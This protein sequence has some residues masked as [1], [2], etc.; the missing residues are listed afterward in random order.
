VPGFHRRQGELHCDE[1]HVGRIAREAG[2]PVHV[3][4]AALL[5]ERLRMLET[6]FTGSQ[7]RLHYAL[8]ANSTLAIVRLMRELG[9][10]ADA[11]SG[12][13]IEVA[14]RAGFEPREILF[15]GVGKTRA[16]LERAVGLGLAAINVE[17][18]G[19]VDRID[20]LAR[21]RGVR[22]RIAVRVN[23]DI[24][25]GSHPHISTGLGA[26]KFGMAAG[27]AARV[28]RD[29][30]TR[31]SL[32]V[33]GL[34]AHIGSQIVDP[35][36]LRR[37]ARTLA[38]LA[39][40]LRAEGIALEHLDLGGGLGIPYRPGDAA[41]TAE[42]Y[43]EAILPAVRDTGLALV[44]E[45][46]RWLVGPAGILVTTVVDIKPRPVKPNDARKRRPA[47]VPSQ[48]VVVDAGMTELLR[49]ALY[50][51][52]H[53]IE[54][55][56]PREGP[57]IDADVVG[58]VCETSDTLGAGRR[59]PP[60]EVGDRLVIRDTGAYG[61]VMASNYNRRPMAAEVLVDASGWRRIRRRQTI[62]DLLRWD[63]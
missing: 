61:A 25:A 14:L 51:A 29:A 16:E 30:A 57:P 26:T 56:S 45:P 37:A 20:A 35:A 44:L 4:S 32:H 22:A 49:P 10:A 60:V 27:D 1:V 54:P 62:D 59:L 18:A 48:F 2:T 21:E 47:G 3:Y 13:E 63:E 12:G 11:N 19:E 36:P 8:K 6:A 39:T 38:D 43:A 15:S 31:P 33:V 28:V 55:V 58:P 50:N 5:A 53:A 34:H 41:L 24:D 40:T 7:H 52:W 17:S 23:P 46:G 9:A 42:E